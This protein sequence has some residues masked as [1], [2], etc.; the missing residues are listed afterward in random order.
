M[1]TSNSPVNG[2]S[3]PAV[4]GNASSHGPKQQDQQ[5][6]GTPRDNHNPPDGART[7][8]NEDRNDLGKIS[9][10]STSELSQIASGKKGPPGGLDATP[11][12][13]VPQGYTVR[14]TFRSAS[15]LPP[16]DLN[17]ASS[18]PF[19]TATLK[20]SGW[21]RHKDDPDLTHRTATIQ[22]TT[23]PEWN[24]EWIVANVPASGFCLKCRLY[25]ED[26]ADTDDRLGNVTIRVES[27]SE[28]W[29]GF[30]P[31]GREFEAKKRVMSKRAYILKAITSLIRS[32]V[33][34]TPKLTVSI[35]VLGKSDPPFAQMCTLGPA[36][37]TK[38]YSPLIGRLAGTK[39]DAPGGN[40]GSQDSKKAKTQKYE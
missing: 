12:P 8:E 28:T 13:N 5:T 35:E 23:E 37:W 32:D 31:P 26:A 11:L 9:Q 29:Q 3:A 16:S 6:N 2:A 21:K 25:D 10:L 38:H 17:T 36:T 1:E 4:N 40:A 14:F 27:I 30:P 39:V 20:A 24:D 7:E 15:N 18:D 22:K 34:M 33:H 19:L